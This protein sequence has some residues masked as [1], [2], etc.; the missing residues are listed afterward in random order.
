MERYL[1]DTNVF[2]QSSH[3]LPSDIFPSYWTK[4]G[5]VIENGIAVIHESVFDELKKHKDPLLNWVKSLEGVKIFKSSP[6]TLQC[7]LA[8]CNWADN[9]G[10]YTAKAL[11]DFK[12]QGL[13]DAWLCAE[14]MASGLVVTTHETSSNSPNRV[15]IPDACAG[16][17][18]KCVSYYDFMRSQGFRF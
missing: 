7:Y 8:V 16:I 6:E 3:T 9:D 5:E 14:A 17:G 2:I 15:K 13:A 1:L 11:R 4:L 12:K 10:R 18:A